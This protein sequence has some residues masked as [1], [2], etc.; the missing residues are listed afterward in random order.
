VWGAPNTQSQLKARHNTHLLTH[1]YPLMCL[2]LVRHTHVYT[3]SVHCTLTY[4]HSTLAMGV[5]TEHLRPAAA[6]WLL[7]AT[8]L[9]LQ[10]CSHANPLNPHNTLCCNKCHASIA[11]HVLMHQKAK[12]TEPPRC[13]LPRTLSV[14]STAGVQLRTARWMLEHWGAAATRTSAS[15][16]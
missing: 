14:P 11:V 16:D 1:T 13:P 15:S 12:S 10:L 6:D 4:M 9:P 8:A 7:T 5:D 3:H 2:I